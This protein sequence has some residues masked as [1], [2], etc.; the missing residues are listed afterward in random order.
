MAWREIGRNFLLVE[1]KFRARRGAICR[2]I[3]LATV[4]GGESGARDDLIVGNGRRFEARKQR[5]FPSAIARNR[6]S[7]RDHAVSRA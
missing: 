2:E 3:P 7:A 4:E 6:C 1:R 5:L